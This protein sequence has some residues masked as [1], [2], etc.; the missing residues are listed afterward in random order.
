[1]KT[2][3]DRFKNA[4]AGLTLDA[5]AVSRYPDLVDLSIG[6][7]DFTT[8]GRIIDAAMRDAKAGHTRY[9]FPQGDPELIT[10]VIRAWKEDFDVDLTKDEILVTASSCL[11]MAQLLIALLNPG[12]EVIVLSPYFAV[13]KEQIS[14]AGGVCIEV[15]CRETDYGPD[16]E[17]IRAAVTERTRAIIVNNPCNPTGALYCRRDLESLAEI[18]KDFDLLILA[19]EIYTRYVFEGEFVPLITLPGMRERVVTLNSFSKNFMMTGWRVGTLI[20]PPEIRRTVQTING[21]MIYTAPSVS[22]RA[23]IEALRLRDD[24]Q[25]L[26][27]SQYGDRI[28]YATNRIEEISWM[29]LSRPKGTFYLFPDI[30]ATGLDSRAFCREALQQAHVL[31]SPGGVFGKAGEGHVRIAVTQ[32]MEKL[33]A[34]FDQLSKMRFSRL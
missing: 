19:D 15:P 4:S 11:G 26:Y 21:A 8:D 28:A 3:A 12:D 23:A 5:D 17:K 24:V 25:R 9:G 27:V 16:P 6:D 33:E 1:M 34:A 31:M 18:A 13:Y 7:T 14:L 30:R 2:I 22:Q 20:A 29:Q 10:A 32:P